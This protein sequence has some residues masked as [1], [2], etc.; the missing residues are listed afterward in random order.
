[1]ADQPPHSKPHAFG[2]WL[3]LGFHL[4]SRGAAAFVIPGVIA[5][6]TIGTPRS[7]RGGL[8]QRARQPEPTADTGLESRA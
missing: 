3:T 5:A 7:E 4:G 2:R 6:A 8:R 1:M